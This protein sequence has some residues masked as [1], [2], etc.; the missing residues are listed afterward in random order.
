MSALHFVGPLP[1]PV[2]G[3]SLINQKM[4]NEFSEK[5]DNLYVYDLAPRYYFSWLVRFSQFLFFGLRHNFDVRRRTMYLGFSGGLR[6]GVDFIFL[7][8]AR[9][10]RYD[11]YIHHHSFSYLN[12]P[13]WLNRFVLRFSREMNHIVLCRCMKERLIEIFGVKSDRITV[14]SNSAFLGDE[15]IMDKTANDLNCQSVRLGFLSNITEAKG[16]FL[17][18]DLLDALSNKGF[19]YDAYIAGPV[20]PTILVR[21]EARLSSNGRVKYVGPVYDQMKINFYDNLD[22]FV[23]PTM[24]VNEAEPVTLWE[25]VASG[26]N[27]VSISRGCISDIVHP[28]FGLVI[29]APERFVE[30]SL[31]HVLAKSLNLIELRRQRMEIIRKF[32][33]ARSNALDERGRLFDK[34]F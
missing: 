25:A 12:K 23:F 14:L 26:L 2:H 21:F 33:D 34:M 18:F 10:L 27:V 31:E 6:Q 24:Y 5:T 19:E 7:L 29:D 3:F 13:N 8:A 20:D 22:F 4:L 17:F 15:W 16:I 9:I 28:D 11:I 30:E 1:N 32:I